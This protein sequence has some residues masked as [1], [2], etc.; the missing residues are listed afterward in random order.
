MSVLC[1]QNVVQCYK[2]KLA[3]SMHFS[4]SSTAFLRNFYIFQVVYLADSNGYVPLNSLRGPPG[5]VAP[6]LY[7]G[8]T[9]G[10]S[11]LES[12]RP[13]VWDRDYNRRYRFNNTRVQRKEIDE[14]LMA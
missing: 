3:I 14:Q 11:E 10:G 2:H 1:V 6:Q 9:G 13:E 4:S 8:S 5:A 7:A 12:W